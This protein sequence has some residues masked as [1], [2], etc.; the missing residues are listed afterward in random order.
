MSF[1]YSQNIECCIECSACN[2][3]NIRQVFYTAQRAITFP[4]SPLYNKSTQQ[5][6][7][8]YQRILRR[9]FRYFDRDG[10]RLWSAQEMNLFQ[11]WILFDNIQIGNVKLHKYCYCYYYYYCYCY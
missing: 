1:S 4:S 3:Q 10:D 5:L 9:V 2:R 8:S 11:V 7:D 6:T